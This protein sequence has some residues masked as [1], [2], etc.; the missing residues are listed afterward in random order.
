M[1]PEGLAQR[2]FDL[3]GVDDMEVSQYIDSRVS[4]SALVEP[5]EPIFVDELIEEQYRRFRNGS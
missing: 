2:K 3:P 4:V 1:S 5:S